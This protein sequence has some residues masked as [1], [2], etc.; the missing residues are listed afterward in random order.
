M[1]DVPTLRINGVEIR[2]IPDAPVDSTTGSGLS[3]VSEAALSR[4]SAT[5]T[6][7]KA[8]MNALKSDLLGSRK[9]AAD[10][11]LVTATTE[12]RQIMTKVRA[13]KTIEL[14]RMTQ[15]AERRMSLHIEG[16]VKP[17]VLPLP[18][19]EEEEAVAELLEVMA[20][21]KSVDQM[22]EEHD[23]NL[24]VGLTSKERAARLERHGLNRLTPPEEE[25]K[26]IQFLKCLVGIFSLLLWAGAFLA[27]GAY[28]IPIMTNSDVEPDVNNLYV[29]L[30]LVFVV[31]LTG[32]VTYVQEAKSSA[33]MKSFES[34]VPSKCTIL[35]DGQVTEVDVITV[36]PGDVCVLSA[37]D[38]APADLRLV[39]CSNLTVDQSAFD[40]ES[41]PVSRNTA[42]SGAD[43]F[44]SARNIALYPC[45]VMTGSGKGIAF[46]TGDHS[47]VAQIAQATQGEERDTPIQREIEHFVKI[48]SVFAIT[49][50]VVFF[51]I[52]LFDSSTV[53]LESVLFAIGIIVAN[54]PEGLLTTVTVSMSLAA[55]RCAQHLTPYQLNTAKR[56]R[57]QSKSS[58]YG[59]NVRV[60]YIKKTPTQAQLNSLFGVYGTLE[61]VR[62]TPTEGTHPTGS[63]L[64]CYADRAQA[65][66][67]IQVVPSLNPAL[68]LVVELNQ[69]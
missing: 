11:E 26:I 45:P 48:I 18:D 41:V 36:V 33:I 9:S 35:V 14:T 12:V 13:R 64:L 49:L 63:A 42:I 57:K 17:K 4:L 54:V 67:A 34:M 24:A 61:S 15:E 40:G 3:R 25:S 37:G 28:V 47:A 66:A 46:S 30:V 53:F 56:E 22:V 16:E 51:T 27:I 23:T 69:S 29:G 65:Q 6:L 21:H 20:H 44:L 68:S 62:I 32:I 43:D 7:P 39:E 58:T 60:S 2:D 52:S 5:G 10:A 8:E 59:R 1:S 55:K 31:V 50:G 19:I 38:K